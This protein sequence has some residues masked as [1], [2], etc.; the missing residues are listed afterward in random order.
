MQILA[1]ESNLTQTAEAYPESFDQVEPC[2]PQAGDDDQANNGEASG[3]IQQSVNGCFKDGQG[4]ANCSATTV[5]GP[6]GDL[7][8]Q[9]EVEREYA[10]GAGAIWY[11][12]VTD[13]G[14]GA[15]EKIFGGA[16]RR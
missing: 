8:C 3:A 4:G 2:D 6:T 10:F 14:P 7:T 1:D 15:S 12:R 11:K 13:S 5:S 9:Q 16:K